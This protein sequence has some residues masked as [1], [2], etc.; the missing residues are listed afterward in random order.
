MKRIAAKTGLTRDDESPADTLTALGEK[1][2]AEA[3]FDDLVADIEAI[4]GQ[5][6]SL[7][8]FRDRL[9]DAYTKMDASDLGDLIARAMT[10]ADLSGRFD[11]Q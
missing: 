9:L 2:Q 7:E 8:E 6:S 1:V 4:L 10:L 3:S 5:V 11:A